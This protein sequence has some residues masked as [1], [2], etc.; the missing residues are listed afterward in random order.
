MKIL[1]VGNIANNAYNN[2]KVL[3][4]AG[5]DC[6]V[7][8]YDYYHIMSC[9]EWE[10]ADFRGEVDDQYT[11]DWSRVDLK[12]FERPAWF[13]Q[14]PRS[15]AIDYLMTRRRGQTRWA[16][17]FWRGMKLAPRPRHIAGAIKRRLRRPPAECETQAF[18]RRV[19][20][21]IDEFDRRFP[22]RED[23]LVAADFEQYRSVVP[24]WKRL[25]EMYDLIE[26]YSTDPILPMLAGN[27]P[28]IAYEHG[29][30]RDIPF[31]ADA[32]GRL[33]SLAYALA[34]AT[35]ITNPDCLV[36]AERLGVRHRVA[37]PHLIDKKYFDSS[38]APDAS[39]ANA[40]ESPYVFC[41][42]RHDWAIK[43]T[44]ILIDAFAAIAADHPGLKL[45]MTSWGADIDRSMARLRHHGLADR[46]VLSPPLHI[47]DLI[48]MT[49]GA[50]V[51]V[52][53]FRYG[54]FGGIGPTALA[55]GTPLVT[56]LDHS[57]SDWCMEPPPYFEAYDV[58]TCER[59]L[60]DALGA[61]SP[62]YAER[63]ER[64]VRRNYWHGDVVT[65]HA[66]LFHERAHAQPVA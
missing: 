50:E 39:W 28:Y 5:F 65:R 61:K 49:R 29:T 3:N 2:A 41:P 19:T 4:D 35:I 23:R 24:E 62:R 64:W 31:A 37:I 14:G 12:G 8:C 40:V 10:D 34:D 36:A 33:T 30:I 7:I 58:E 17:M 53:Q 46:V 22:D 54:V 6:D 48:R 25:F 15:M 27:R 45:V 32:R 18:D 13:A 60:R 26:A 47:H 55:V 1:H 66:E 9:P 20:E 11:P 16:S 38:I 56:H 59:A 21:L 43:G 63:L 57:K 52:D 51:L 44:N 42:A